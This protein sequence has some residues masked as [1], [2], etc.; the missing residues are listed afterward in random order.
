MMN[1]NMN[2]KIKV[3]INDKYKNVDDHDD[4][5][6]RSASITFRLLGIPH[7]RYANI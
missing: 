6:L 2:M 4:A 5:V 7:N 3:K 1:M